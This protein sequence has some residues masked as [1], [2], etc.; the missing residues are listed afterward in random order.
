M[1]KKIEEEMKKSKRCFPFFES[2]KINES[3]IQFSRVKN[4]ANEKNEFIFQYKKP[5]TNFLTLDKDPTFL[6]FI[7]QNEDNISIILENY[8]FQN[9]LLGIKDVEFLESLKNIEI[10]FQLT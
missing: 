1:K 9:N 8:H 3:F 10:D 2:K 6:Y 5:H 7:F 4:F